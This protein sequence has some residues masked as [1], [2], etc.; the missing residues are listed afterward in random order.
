MHLSQLNNKSFGLPAE[1]ATLLGWF[2]FEAIY[3]I[4]TGVGITATG[5]RHTRAS[6][7]WGNGQG[8]CSSMYAW[9]MMVSKLIDLHG[10]YCHGAKYKAYDKL[11]K[12]FIIG[13]MSFVDDFNLSNNAERYEKVKDVLKRTQED[14]QLWNDI[15]NASGGALELN[16]CFMQVIYFEFAK[17]GAP[18]VGPPKDEFYVELTNRTTG[19]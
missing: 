10:K 6:G 2:L 4:K 14:A 18:F 16:K 9:G 17:S 12:E 5:Y 13:M 1:I 7:V 19:K 11:L 3:Y 15:M 8:A